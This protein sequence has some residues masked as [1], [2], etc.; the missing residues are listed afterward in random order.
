MSSFSREVV[1]E[2]HA[3][4]IMSNILKQV[5]LKPQGYESVRQDHDRDSDSFLTE[6]AEFQDSLLS[7]CPKH[8]WPKAS[9]LLGCPRPILIQPFHQRMVTELHEALTTAITDIVQRW[10]SDKEANFPGRM[11]LVPG[12]E[13]LLKVS[14]QNSFVS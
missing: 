7:I 6:H 2:C 9:N 14:E 10:W 5:H 11:P 12:E 8:V 3:H 1:Q 13:Q 4:A